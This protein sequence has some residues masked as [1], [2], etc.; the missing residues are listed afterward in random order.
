M[1][2]KLRRISKRTLAMFLGVLMLITS[3]GIG[4]LITANAATTIYFKNTLNWS[5]VYAYRPEGWDDKGCKNTGT[6][7][8]MTKVSGTKDLY[9]CSVNNTDRIAF[10]NAKMDNYG[11]FNGNSA[12]YSTSF[13]S[14]Y[15]VYYPGTTYKTVNTT[16][17]YNEDN[18]AFWIAYDV[19]LY[20]DSSFASGWNTSSTASMSIDAT[21]G[22]YKYEFTPTS[23]K[24]EWFRILFGGSDQYCP[25]SDS[26]TEIGGES[27]K[28]VYKYG[29]S[30]AFKFNSTTTNDYTIW[31]D[32]VSKNVWYTSV[33]NISPVASSVSLSASPN[34][35]T[36][37]AGTSITFTATATGVQ[38]G[39]TYT[40]Y[41]DDVNK[42]SGA[43]STY[44][45]NFPNGGTHKVKV[46][47]SKSGYS[48]VESSELTYTVNAV[49]GIYIKKTLANSLGYL[50][51]WSNS[52]DKWEGNWPGA[53]YSDWSDYG[54]YYYKEYTNAYSTFKAILNNNGSS[55]TEN[56]DA[57]E[58]GKNYKIDSASANSKPTLTEFI[59]ETKYT[60][61][62]AVDDSSHGSVSPASVQAGAQN[63]VSLP[64]PT[65]AYGWKFKN[66]T[67]SSGSITLA[68]ASNA[69]SATVKAS[70][71]GTVTAQFEPD[72]SKNIYIVGR[73]RYRK[74]SSSGWTYTGANEGDW[75]DSSTK[76][77]M[78]A[79]STAFLY[80]LETNASLAELS[81]D[82]GGQHQYFHIKDLSANKT[83]YP[84]T[85][86]D[87]TITPG[88]TLGETG[89]NNMRF[90][91]N[92][93]DSPVTI[94]FNTSTKKIYYSVP[95]YYNITFTNEIKSGNTTTGHV[96]VNSDTSGTK[97]VKE[98]NSYTVEITPENGYELDT[99]KING[100]SKTATY[101]SS[102]NKYTYTQTNCQADATVSVTLRKKTYT[103]TIVAAHGSYHVDKG[104]AP[105]TT[106]FTA[107]IGDTFTVTTSANSKYEITGFANAGTGYSGG[108]PTITNN[109]Y[110]S[111]ADP[112]TTSQATANY[113]MGY[114]N[115][116][117][118][119]EYVSLIL[120]ENTSVV[121]D[122]ITTTIK[123]HGM[124]SSD[125]SVLNEGSTAFARHYNGYIPFIEADPDEGYKF[126][127]TIKANNTAIGSAQTDVTH[128]SPAGRQYSTAA[129]AVITVSATEKTPT[130]Y[131]LAGGFNNWHRGTE[132]D[133]IKFEKKSGESAGNIAYAKVT[134]KADSH[135]VLEAITP[136]EFKVVDV[137]NSSSPV[138]YGKNNTSFESEST[139][140]QLSSS[141]SNMSM[142]TTVASDSENTYIFELDLSTHKLSV[143]YPEQE[144]KYIVKDENDNEM[145]NLPF[146]YFDDTTHPTHWR[147]GGPNNNDVTIKVKVS[148]GYR[149]KTTNGVTVA[150]QTTPRPTNPPSNYDPTSPTITYPSSSN[151]WYYTIKFKMG[152]DHVNLTIKL[153]KIRITVG[154][155]ITTASIKDNFS[156]S[157][158]NSA[159]TSTVSE[160]T[161]GETYKIKASVR[162][163]YDQYKAYTVANSSTVLT[164][165]TKQGD[166]VEDNDHTWW[167]SFTAGYSD[168]NATVNFS[169]AMPTITKSK[170]FNVLAGQEYPISEYISVSKIFS[171]SYSK[172]I[173]TI[174]DS[175]SQTVVSETTVDYTDFIHATNP[176]KFTAPNTKGSY[177]IKFKA[178][179]DPTGVSA[180]TTEDWIP[181]DLDVTYALKP[182]NLYLE[183][184]SYTINVSVTIKNENGTVYQDNDGHNLANIPFSKITGTTIYELSRDIPSNNTDLHAWVT[185][186]SN[187]AQDII[188]PANKLS[189]AGNEGLDVWL[190]A[191]AD[192]RV[193]DTFTTA[194]YDPVDPNTKRI[195]LCKPA[196]W[197]NWVD[198][199][200]HWWG[201]PSTNEQPHSTWGNYQVKDLGSK[202]TSNGKVYYYY[203]DIAKDANYVKFYDKKNDKSQTQNFL[204]SE[205]T[206]FLVLSNG[207]NVEAKT[208]VVAPAI[209]SYIDTLTT[210]AGNTTTILAPAVGTKKDNGYV[211]EVVNV[212]EEDDA[213][214]AINV[215]TNDG[216]VVV[217][218]N[219]ITTP[220][221][222]ARV[223]FRV[224][225]TLYSAESLTA[226]DENSGDNHGEDYIDKTVNVTVK[227]SEICSGVRLMSYGSNKS[228]ININKIDDNYPAT[229]TSVDT[230][231]NINDKQYRGSTTGTT[232]GLVEFNSQA[233]KATIKY[234][235][236]DGTGIS[237][238]AYT[239]IELTARINT[240]ID[241]VGVH[242]YG[243]DHWVEGDDRSVNYTTDNAYIA[244]NGTDYIKYFEEYPYTLINIHFI[245]YDYNTTREDGTKNYIYDAGWI[246]K[247]YSDDSDSAYQKSHIKKEF[248]KFSEV[249]HSNSSE[250]FDFDNASYS[251]YKSEIDSAV[252]SVLPNISSKYFTYRYC[253]DADHVTD[254]ANGDDHNV[255]VTVRLQETARNYSVYYGSEKVFENK[256]YQEM[257]T[258]DS[259][260]LGSIDPRIDGDH[261]VKWI[262]HE[263]DSTGKST[264][265][266]TGKEY[267]FRVTKDT[268]LTAEPLGQ[269]EEPLTVKGKTSAVD[270]S[271]S[272]IQYDLISTNPVEYAE[273][274]FQN[275]HITDFF[276][277]DM[278]EY[279][280]PVTDELKHHDITFVG[281]GVMFYS[282]DESGK[283]KNAM[284][285][286]GFI[287]SNTSLVTSSTKD[288]VIN[289]I[290]DCI[291]NG[292]T[293]F[294]KL[295][296]KYG[297]KTNGAIS[298]GKGFM[299]N[300]VP[301]N[302]YYK[303]NSS[304]ESYDVI[305]HNDVYRYYSPLQAYL[306]TYTQGFV[307]KEAN[308]GKKMRLYSY[309][310]YSYV[311]YEKDEDVIYKVV[312]SDSYV[313]A[314]QYENPMP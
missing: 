301:Y 42:Q 77:K 12:A 303:Y 176:A 250:E 10:T 48:D 67:T 230:L 103:V 279:R 56:S 166:V 302:E 217:T 174:V 173:Y 178:K 244:I 101:N 187:P 295:E 171:N 272:Q 232:R 138:W 152:R 40:F 130:T 143:R 36:I 223:T 211:G 69:S 177:T 189:N 157:L 50:Y 131:R 68:N 1:K 104:G 196:G 234:A 64:V 169:A 97:R 182:V 2:T 127:I 207:P 199:G 269:T 260:N 165:L 146:T 201:E 286:N 140:M 149:I 3:L 109:A 84:S 25:N 66:W 251:E 210:N 115:L 78:T 14:K 65:A 88:T 205:G 57:K 118:T 228:T 120:L 209:Y 236:C 203:Y 183:A 132:T 290:K 229:I 214:N 117:I 52:D 188:I 180:V 161:M 142:T 156:A 219:Q 30:G 204:L 288:S 239:K 307:N 249:R 240:R 125:I 105:Y 121:D 53:D 281:G 35:T 154:H 70:A 220:T 246:E 221:A 213:D 111:D 106:S 294:E 153:E 167:I 305:K 287:D 102:T 59:P 98:N 8:K 74:T 136:Y 285:D 29:E 241:N 235:K 93:E 96:T 186:G 92:L 282:L 18:S 148:N 306:Y 300:Y 60:I 39:A 292:E 311:E 15:P 200:I 134:T 119:V 310:I 291:T 273:V 112:Y 231:L 191:T 309:Y 80:K 159:G 22:Y 237:S 73:F 172:I 41:V 23:N 133:V 20:G 255:D 76:I 277:F 243:F 265:V 271:G 24:T 280:D 261:V 238:Y 184:H 168:V 100:V 299:Y 222:T 82:L 5:N 252:N 55:Q 51:L 268:Y 34:S 194:S 85:N 83:F 314:N 164:N 95:V 108:T 26:D 160:F 46:I 141:G 72:M 16:K 31:L 193:A 198:I 208:S 278:D 264:V 19:K 293:D 129:D 123:Y 124:G 284:Y 257:V 226:Y 254:L 37:N 296:L 145:A 21:T 274:L 28:Q 137:A 175:N 7:T 110:P 45:Y 17:Y 206:N 158:Y 62:L 71:A 13:N 87:M 256:K 297:T 192:A 233:H 195:Y 289:Q 6:G 81:A 43:T 202:T 218:A 27:N 162:T 253:G 79:T 63:A 216:K 114:S 267:K 248:S 259:D 283:A 99:L 139:D 47:V 275:F 32:P 212:T 107:Q 113:T 313:D 181:F 150:N 126:D 270:Y 298:S 276:N 58:T 90:N 258:C 245:Y 9:S 170:D 185:V 308:S 44:T 94:Y 242:H 128:G 151:N 225:G 163:S 75:N 38:S 122:H 312:L 54:D 86:T 4:S 116:T 266:H 247:P 304:T 179:N 11:N 215:T 155:N 197:N 91:S 190:E 33:S 49:T 61:T 262:N 144:I 227:N 263:G 147:Y 89:S 135:S 224:R